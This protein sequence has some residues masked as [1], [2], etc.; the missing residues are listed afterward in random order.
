MAELLPASNARV[1]AVV[2]RIVALLSLPAKH[3]YRAILDVDT[4]VLT[5][6][7]NVILQQKASRF[8]GWSPL[9]GFQKRNFVRVDTTFR[10]KCLD[11][12]QGDIFLR[13]IDNAPEIFGGEISAL[14]QIP[15]ENAHGIPIL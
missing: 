1:M 13:W 10:F 2:V 6:L 12:F 5:H 7:H 8:S 14:L 15:R 11:E 3:K 4:V 9:P